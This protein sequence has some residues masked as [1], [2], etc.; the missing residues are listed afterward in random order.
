MPMIKK[1]TVQTDTTVLY[2]A[3]VSHTQMCQVYI[4]HT[5]TDEK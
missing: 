3:S 2:P 4:N 1:N 5:D